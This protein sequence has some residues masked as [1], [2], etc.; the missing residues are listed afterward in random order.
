MVCLNMWQLQNAQVFYRGGGMWTVTAVVL[1][2]FWLLNPGYASGE[3]KCGMAE[4]RIFNEEKRRRS[5]GRCGVAVLLLSSER[6]ERNEVLDDDLPRLFVQRPARGPDCGVPHVTPS[7][8][9]KG[10]SYQPAFRI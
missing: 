9:E 2:C 7:S 4:V 10:L 3:G 6:T 8:H 1:A 5:G